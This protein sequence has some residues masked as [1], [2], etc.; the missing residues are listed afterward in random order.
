MQRHAPFDADWTVSN[1]DRNLHSG[2]LGRDLRANTLSIS[3]GGLYSSRIMSNQRILTATFLGAALVFASAF[4]WSQTS[5]TGQ[6][7]SVK[8]DLKAAGHDTKAATK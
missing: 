4:G 5:S 7:D 2:P 1:G 3:L 8:H 6:D